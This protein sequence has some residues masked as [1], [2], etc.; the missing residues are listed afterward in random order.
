[1][2]FYSMYLKASKFFKGKIINEISYVEKDLENNTVS[3]LPTHSQ[4]LYFHFH[5][6]K[7]CVNIDLSLEKHLM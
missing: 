1:M 3:F 4:K 7:M 5:Y 2:T 6:N